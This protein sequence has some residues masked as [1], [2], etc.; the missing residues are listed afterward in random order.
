MNNQ[1]QNLI[2]QHFGGYWAIS[3]T[4]HDL[5][6]IENLHRSLWN[7]KG[8]QNELIEIGPTC[9]YFL[10]EES[11][12]IKARRAAFMSNWE[13]Y[14]PKCQSLKKKDRREHGKTIFKL[15]TEKAQ[16]ELDNIEGVYFLNEGTNYID[17]PCDLDYEEKPMKESKISKIPVSEDKEANQKKIEIPIKNGRGRPVKY[18][19]KKLVLDFNTNQIIKKTGR[20][21]IGSKLKIVWIDRNIKSED[22]VYGSTPISSEGIVEIK[23]KEK[24]L[25]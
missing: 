5:E 2:K 17:Y 10:I 11:L 7:H 9:K 20:F 23:K 21:K 15:A 8:L 1:K 12:W 25:V 3:N 22:F 6:T 13:N 14:F 19:L 16:K 24:V 18:N 4:N